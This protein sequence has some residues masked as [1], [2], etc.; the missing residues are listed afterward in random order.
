MAR[1]GWALP[2]ASVPHT[3]TCE[4]CGQ[5]SVRPTVTAATGR[6][7]AAGHTEVE[8]GHVVNVKPLER[9]PVAQ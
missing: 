8:P 6:L 7:L 1:N 3:V 9:G 2:V 4:T 5:L